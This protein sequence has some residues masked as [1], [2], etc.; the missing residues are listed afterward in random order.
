MIKKLVQIIL[1][2]T[3]GIFTVLGLLVLYNII[4]NNGDVITSPDN[5]FFIYFVPVSA[6][7]A[8][9]IQFALTLPF[10]Q[11]FK[12]QNKIYDLT[13]FQFT[14]L[15]CIFSG[16]AFGLVFWETNL[17]MNEFISVSILGIIAFAV[18]WAVNLI[19]L[20]KLDNL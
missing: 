8:I 20:K 5:G 17:G 13:L 16:L 10:W 14:S 15:L 7:I 3:F 12:K 6:L 9:T 18:Y 4:D 2:P 19:T 1:P 11:K